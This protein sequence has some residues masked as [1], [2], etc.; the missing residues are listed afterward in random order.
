MGRFPEIVPEPPAGSDAEK[1]SHDSFSV[2]FH[3]SHAASFRNAP[4]CLSL[5]QVH[6]GLLV[7]G[8]HVSELLINPLVTLD[9]DAAKDLLQ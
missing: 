3:L 2:L 8:S 4:A 1:P 9:F 6:A 5:G 7:L